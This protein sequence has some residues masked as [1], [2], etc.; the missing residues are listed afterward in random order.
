MRTKHQFNPFFIVAVS[1]AF[2]ASFD[3]SWFVVFGVHLPE[4]MA[5][6]IQYDPHHE[7]NCR[8]LILMEE[9]VD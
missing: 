9:V 3:C 2:A 7:T 8:S 6:Q 5:V 1:F 4:A